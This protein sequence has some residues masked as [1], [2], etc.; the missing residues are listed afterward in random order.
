MM[1]RETAEKPRTVSSREGM[2]TMREPL[3]RMRDWRLSPSPR[4]LRPSRAAKV[5]VF[6]EE[7]TA[8]AFA[9]AGDEDEAAGL[10]DGFPDGADGGEGRLAPLAGAIEDDLMAVAEEELFLDG[11][12]EEVEAV[13]S[14]G[15]GVG[16]HGWGSGGG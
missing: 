11:V 6:A 7:F 14:E 5:E 2:A 3:G 16:T 9:T 1:R 15:D 10:G 12:R 13:A 4:V 8:L